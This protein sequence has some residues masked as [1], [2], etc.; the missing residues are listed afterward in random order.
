MAADTTL[1]CQTNLDIGQFVSDSQGSAWDIVAA[2]TPQSP[3]ASPV[4]TTSTRRPCADSILFSSKEDSGDAQAAAAGSS[5][6]S[7]TSPSPSTVHS[8]ASAASAKRSR[9][10][11]HTRQKSNSAASSS[12]RFSPEA[13]KALQ[14]ILHS[15]RNNPYPSDELIENIRVEFGLSSKQ[16]RNW[17]ALQRFRHMVRMEHQGTTRWRFRSETSQNS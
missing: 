4:S 15:I 8:D 3:N 11:R 14:Q 2:V 9:D 10:A 6:A 12:G 17:F 16:V 13:Q 1:Q 5:A 7:S